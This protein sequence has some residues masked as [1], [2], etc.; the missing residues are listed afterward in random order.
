MG[1]RGIFFIALLMLAPMA[2][3]D[4]LADVMDPSTYIPRSDA[5]LNI[6]LVDYGQEHTPEDLIRIK[7]LLEKRF[8]QATDSLI[9]LN[10]A[11][12][13]N[14]PYRNLI[15]SHPEYQLPNITDPA[16]LQRLWY[17][18]FVNE[19]IMQEI[20]DVVKT[21]LSIGP[22]LAGLDAV[23]TITG[24]QFDGLGF[25]DGRIAVTES[26]REIAWALPDGGTTEIVTDGAAVDELI[27]EIGHTLF[28][29]HTSTQCQKPG[30]TY[31][32]TKLCCATS[33]A[34]D[35]V[36]SYCRDRKK[37]NDTDFFFGFKDCQLRNIKNLVIP[38]MLSGG[39]W[40][41][42]NREICN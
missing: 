33:D 23:A 13:T 17:Y 5:T 3:A 14:I 39:G 10:V 9:K 35:D 26:P 8:Y 34:R 29:G 31:E 1:F 19:N 40:M 12:T 2:H 18:D 15:S 22:S 11:I 4:T 25:A 24:A 37:V 27:H 36:M 6:A 42:Q 30:M 21:S 16:R 7:A 32:E 28:L 20:Y 41:I 38:A